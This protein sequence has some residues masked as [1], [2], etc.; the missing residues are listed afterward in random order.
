M[1][2]ACP[3]VRIG[4]TSFV[5]RGARGI[6]LLSSRLTAL[7]LSRGS[8]RPAPRTPSG[9]PTRRAVFF[10]VQPPAA[11]PLVRSPFVDKISLFVD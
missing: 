9:A 3:S 2:I 6:P 1:A 5:S 4:H 11:R 10:I 7:R 8:A